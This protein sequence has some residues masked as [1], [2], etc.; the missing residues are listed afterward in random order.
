MASGK[1][2][3]RIQVEKVLS[4]DRVILNRGEVH[5]V[6]P[7]MR[8]VL[9][10]VSEEEILDPATGESLG[11]L[12]LIKGRRR[13][14]LRAGQDVCGLQSRQRVPRRSCWRPCDAGLDLRRAFWGSRHLRLRR[15]FSWTRRD[16]IVE[17]RSNSHP[18]RGCRRTGVTVGVSG[19]LVASGAPRRFV[20][21]RKSL[22]A[23]EPPIRYAATR[24][25]SPG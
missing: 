23:A 11:Q 17:A 1:S 10:N 5:G 3:T 14:N 13:G 25:T 4:R 8:F 15:S 19:S 12:E 24:T 2:S 6:K 22:P 18:N 21:G 7:G 16:A 20:A 9:Y